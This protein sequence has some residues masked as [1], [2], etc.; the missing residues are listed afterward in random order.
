MKL[1]KQLWIELVVEF[2]TF[3]LL[4]ASIT[5]LWRNNVLLLAIV[6]VECLFALARWHERH[7]VSFLLTLAVF[8]TLAEIAF[9]H[10]GAWQYAN[11]TLLG[12]PLWFPLAFGTAGLTGQRLARTTAAVWGTRERSLDLDTSQPT[13]HG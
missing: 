3:S 5:L 6:L 4:V 2:A 12:I 8:G 13:T 1:T 9:T 10:S 11:P 7:D